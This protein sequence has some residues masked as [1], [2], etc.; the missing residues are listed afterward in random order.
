[1]PAYE[2]LHDEVTAYLNSRFGILPN[3]L[4]GISFSEKND[5]IWAASAEAPLGIRARRLPGLRALRRTPEGLKPT[6]AFLRFIG[7]RISSSCVEIG[8]VAELRRFLLG[9]PVPYMVPDGFVAVSFRGDILGC[10]VARHRQVLTLIPTHMRHE[11]LG[12]LEAEMNT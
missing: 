9:Q 10:G 8:T 2:G 11:L 12:C 6:S 7:E 4:A 3:S 5:E 1:M